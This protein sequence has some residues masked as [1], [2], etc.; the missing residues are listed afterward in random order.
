MERKLGV[1]VPL[2]S[3]YESATT[4]VAGLAARIEAT[5]KREASETSPIVFFVHPHESSLLTLRHFSGPL[6]SDYRLMGLLPEP[7]GGYF[8][9]SQ[10]IEGLARP[11]LDTVRQAQPRG[12]YYIAGY[13]LGGL[14]AYELAGRLRAAGEPVAWLG[15]L[16]TAAPAADARGFAASFLASAATRVAARAAS[17]LAKTDQVLRR[18]LGSQPARLHLR[19]PELTE[20][21][22]ELSAAR[23]AARYS[24]VGHDA[25]MDLFVSESRIAGAAATPW[26]GTR[27]TGACSASTASMTIIW[28]WQPAAKSTPSRQ[29]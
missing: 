16:D 12:P 27:S 6:G 26:G 29:W 17:A 25:A 22:D 8:D 19:R 20:D 3:F 2:A 23:L 9:R 21:F 15:I 7:A 13:S 18:E 24:C 11:M 14:L 28:R 1:E 10:S 5:R 4:T